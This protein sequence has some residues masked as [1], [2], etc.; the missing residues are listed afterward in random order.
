M[1]RLLALQKIIETGSFTKA[2]KALGYTQSSIS[3][4]ITSLENEFNVK[5][6]KRSRSG[7][8]L[9]PAG[10]KLYPHF[11]AMLRQYDDTKVIADQI[12]GLETGVVKIGAINSLSRYWLPSLI[13]GFEKLHPNIHFTLYQGDY[14]EIREDLLSGKIDLGF[15]K[16]PYTT[17]L[18]VSPLKNERLLAIIPTDH[19]LASQ[20]KATLTQLYETSQNIILIPEGSH[21]SVMAAFEKLNIYPTIK[22]KIQDDY[23]VMA[24]VEAGLGISFVSE[25]MLKNC[26]FKIKGLETAPKLNHQISLAYQDSSTLSIASK[27]FLEYVESQKNN[28]I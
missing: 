11:Q 26:P 13:R 17:G 2:A 20:S 27:R 28:L 3:Q 10:E 6:L 16:P 18:K 23:T 25:L 1:N 9:T 24:M 22:D 19:P 21:S 8:S 15:L 4:S 5:I 14:S 12:N 7:I